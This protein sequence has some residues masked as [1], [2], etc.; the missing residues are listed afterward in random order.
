[1]KRKILP[2][3]DFFFITET[4]VWITL[5]SFFLGLILPAVASRFGKVL[6]ADPGTILVRLW[7]RPRWPIASTPAKTARLRRKWGKMMVVSFAWG[8][9]LAA[10]AIAT[11]LFLPSQMHVWA[12]VFIYFVALGIV[13]DQ[14]FC[15]LPDF[16]T[17]P[18]L[19]LGFLAAHQGH[20]LTM[21]DSLTGAFFG[22]G[23]SVVAVIVMTFFHR[24]VFGAGDVKM[25]TALG[26]WLG[27]YGLNL[28]LLISFMLF[29]AWSFVRRQG[30]GPF[31]P[32]LGIA[33]VFAL[34]YLYYQ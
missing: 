16:V 12:M 10:L 5:I 8:I 18:L 21:T 4:M 9:T 29:S 26:A 27:A 20:F 6:P 1:M 28:A 7:H 22:Y 15:L 13:I 3:K 24:A 19:L 32:A 31:G 11:G 25:L 34:F 2:R 17:I 30:M 14:Q 23:V 33:A